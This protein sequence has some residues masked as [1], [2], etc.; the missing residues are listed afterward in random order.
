MK[1]LNMGLVLCSLI[2]GLLRVR[3]EGER[4]ERREQRGMQGKEERLM[5]KYLKADLAI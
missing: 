5:M 1:L 4:R 3:V 2:V